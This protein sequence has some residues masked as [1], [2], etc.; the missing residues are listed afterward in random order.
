MSRR[1]QHDNM[2]QVSNGNP[3]FDGVLVDVLPVDEKDRIWE[4]RTVDV[5]PVGGQKIGRSSERQVR[6]AMTFNSIGKRDI[7]PPDELSPGRWGVLFHCPNDREGPL[8]S[9]FQ[10]YKVSSK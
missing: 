10:E 8:V 9:D 4:D 7:V 2:A 5:E 6:T 3:S 1:K